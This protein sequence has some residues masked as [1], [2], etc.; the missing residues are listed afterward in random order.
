[1]HSHL[2]DGQLHVTHQHSCDHKITLR[3]A[4]TR[5]LLS[6]ERNLSPSFA[7]ISSVRTVHMSRAEVKERL[8]QLG[9]TSAVDVS[10]TRLEKKSMHELEKKMKKAG[11]NDNSNA[12]S[13][14]SQKHK[15]EPKDLCKSR[16][17]PV[18]GHETKPKLT[19][20]IKETQAQREPLRQE[21]LDFG[22]CVLATHIAASGQR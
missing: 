19:R 5:I 13:G 14:L 10:C 22:G 11:M 6:L 1:M 17:I 12:R 21:I 8:E 9:W 15:T 4:A 18:S 16:S 7:A 20:K 3:S 2:R